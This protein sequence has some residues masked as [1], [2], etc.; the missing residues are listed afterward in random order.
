MAAL[1]LPLAVEVDP[2]TRAAQAGERAAGI[3]R[4]DWDVDARAGALGPGV[5]P[6]F[7]YVRDAI[8]FE[9]YAGVLR[10]ASGAYMA[11]AGNA[12]DRALL[13]ARLLQLKGLRTRFA[14]GTLA[15]ADQD[16]LWQRV[17]DT[18]IPLA[19][20]LG[21][22]SAPS[23][24]AT[25]F[26]QRIHAR[27]SRDFGAVRGA[28][29]E[30]LPPVTRPSREQVLAEMNPHVWVQAEV[31]GSW[32]DLDP[33]FAEASPG[34]AVAKAERTADEMPAD[35][36]QRV[37]IRLVVEQLHDGK[38]AL[39]NVLELSRNAVDL[40]D[41][42]VFVV[43]S[44]GKPI[45]LAGLGAAL[46]G[47]ATW[48]P[49]LWIDGDFTWG[50]TFTI[51]EA[52]GAAAS[53]NGSTAQ[54]PQGR[55]LLDVQDALSSDPAPGAEPA[56]PV[57]V[58]EWLEF[59]LTAPGCSREITRRALAE[60]GGAAWRAASP[61]L[62]AGLQPLR[63]DAQGPMAMRA[64]HNV[65][66]SAGPHNLSDYADALQDLAVSSLG[67][68]AGEEPPA[69]EDFGASVWPTALQNFTWMVWTDHVIIPALDDTPGVRVYADRPRI[70][71]FTFGPDV[72]GGTVVLSDLRRDDLR[73]LAAEPARAGALAE[74]K[75]WYALLQGALEQEGIAEI[76]VAF[77]ADPGSVE[78]TSSRMTADG[79]VVMT[80]G[81]PL[82]VTPR[83]P[84]PES[85]ARLTLAL[86]AGSVVVA[87]VSGLGANGAWWEIL[88]QTGEVRAVGEL[89]LHSGHGGIPG[90]TNP[91]RH[92]KP[93]QQNPFG[94][95]KPINMP[96]AAKEARDAARRA[97]NARRTAENVKNY[98]QARNKMAR[99][100]Q[101]GGNEYTV[102]V[103]AMM[104]VSS[105]AHAALMYATAVN[106][107]AAIDVLAQ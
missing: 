20:G 29:G 8:R 78:T 5:A 98:N 44:P 81:N 49:A 1:A 75:L 40:V 92:I 32:L 23:A 59:E 6:A 51:D 77:G 68:A 64:V 80:P 61:L 94:G 31:G 89:G 35:M 24:A 70:A 11:R 4:R 18:S 85:A 41:Q 74:K 53:G 71:I 82:P 22:G 34:F 50:K 28:L 9:A 87:P 97:Q 38:L 47:Y 19:P 79:V 55:G 99:S 101:R 27:A 107:M 104:V 48:T 33:S 13:L 3:S 15:A 58:A 10:G 69:A 95:Q 14:F 26:R 17:F 37:N 57:F 93:P 83:Q 21:A 106:V 62:A 76:L 54:K 105:A 72:D 102:L 30:R 90:N 60:R 43:H 65:W 63:R 88:A 42:Q 16:R 91:L 52:G 84:E 46:G 66:F 36:F 86:G 12:A 56:A 39:A 25:A 67:I 45:A 73:A 100:A 7:H 96:E 2:M 103:V